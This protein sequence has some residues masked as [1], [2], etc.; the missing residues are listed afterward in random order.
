ML[1]GYA[2]WL[3][4]GIKAIWIVGICANSRSRIKSEYSRMFPLHLLYNHSVRSCS[5]SLLKF[6]KWNQGD[7]YSGRNRLRFLHIRILLFCKL[8]SH[9][10]Q[11]KKKLNRSLSQ[12]NLCIH[13]FLLHID[14]SKKTQ[15]EI[16]ST[17]IIP[18]EKPL[19]APAEP[20]IIGKPWSFLTGTWARRLQPIS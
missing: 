20:V 12:L 18:L 3:F 11:T 15:T 10:Q 1:R 8:F 13:A 6:A 7:Q 9:R 14:L 16:K 4:L 2:R 5:I 19:A 17:L